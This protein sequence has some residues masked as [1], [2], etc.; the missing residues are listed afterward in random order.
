M[1][2]AQQARQPAGP[3]LQAASTKGLLPR[4]PQAPWMGRGGGWPQQSSGRA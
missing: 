3:P 1:L 2:A 4:F